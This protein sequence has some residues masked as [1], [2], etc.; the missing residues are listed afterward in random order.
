MRSS[1]IIVPGTFSGGEVESGTFH[2]PAITGKSQRVSQRVTDAAGQHANMQ[3]G[4][5]SGA[6][7]WVP[8]P[9][10][11]EVLPARK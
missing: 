11:E 3:L 4:S 9:E 6:G 10:L 2:R 1:T 7:H 8:D 5:A